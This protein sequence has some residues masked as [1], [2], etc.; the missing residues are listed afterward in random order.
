[1]FDIKVMKFL[2]NCLVHL[3]NN[4]ATVEVNNIKPRIIIT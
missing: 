4:F 1:M 2:I 3:T